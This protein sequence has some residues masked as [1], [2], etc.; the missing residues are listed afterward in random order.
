MANCSVQT[1]FLF[2]KK[3]CI[4]PSLGN[5]AK[6]R[7]F[8]CQIHSQEQHDGT[9]LCGACRTV[10]EP[11]DDYSYTTSSES[12]SGAGLGASLGGL[13]GGAA[14]ASESDRQRGDSQSGDSGSSDSGSSD[15]GS[16]SSD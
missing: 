4:H 3:P 13:S 15:S 5:C 2:W 1:G 10:D 9:L 11:D 8:V 14:S 12:A 7:K 6:C 16:S